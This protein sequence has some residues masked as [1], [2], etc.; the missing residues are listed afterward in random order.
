MRLIILLSVWLVAFVSTQD[1]VFWH[2]DSLTWEHFNTV[3]KSSETFD[4]L[5]ASGIQISTKDSGGHISIEL[6]SYVDPSESWVKKDAKTPRLLNHEKRHFDITEV[7]RRKLCLA[8]QTETNLNSENLNETVD[9]LFDNAMQWQ[10]DMSDLYDNETKHGLNILK[11]K[12]WDL[13]IDA[14]LLEYES[15]SD[16][17]VH[18]W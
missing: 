11:Q 9:S 12:K 2:S 17:S 7:S 6:K 3:E 14:W 13:K 4:A 15:L 10:S 1:L 8:L 5:I 16:L 18:L